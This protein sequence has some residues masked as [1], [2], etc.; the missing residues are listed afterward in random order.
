MKLSTIARVQCRAD[1]VAQLERQ[2]AG[3]CKA[4]RKD[5]LALHDCKRSKGDGD[6]QEDD[7]DDD[8]YD[9][10]NEMMMMIICRTRKHL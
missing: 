6:D 8:D 1:K 2:V 9:D 10:D 4:R 3:L 5:F 7:E